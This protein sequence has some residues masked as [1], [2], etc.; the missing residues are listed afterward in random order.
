MPTTQ[1]WRVLDGLISSAGARHVDDQLMR[2][3]REA[4]YR[5]EAPWKDPAADLH[6]QTKRVVLADMA[7]HAAT[8]AELTATLRAFDD[9]QSS[10]AQAW[11]TG[12]AG[13][14]LVKRAR[15]GRLPAG[16]EDAVVAAGGPQRL[17]GGYWG[18]A[19]LRAGGHRA[20]EPETAQATVD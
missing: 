4:A 6:A 19:V 13:D 14:I 11:V 7:Q 9:C 17:S 20:P 16:W 18:R 1:E 2:P 12:D 3:F 5:G 10:R 15:R 8:P